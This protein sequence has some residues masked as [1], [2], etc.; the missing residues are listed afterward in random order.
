MEP[1]RRWHL[2]VLFGLGVAA[3]ITLTLVGGFASGLVTGGAAPLGLT[4]GSEITAAALW[5]MSAPAIAAGGLVLGAGMTGGWALR[6]QRTLQRQLERIEEQLQQA[7]AQVRSLERDCEVLAADGQRLD[8]SLSD[9]IAQRERT[10]QEAL[11]RQGALEAQLAQMQRLLAESNT[12][13]SDDLRAIEADVANTW[14]ENDRLRRRLADLE[15]RNGDLELELA[16][17]LENLEEVW[18]HA[19]E[20]QGETGTDPDGG[21]QY[22]SVTEA[23]AAAD[24]EFGDILTIWDSAKEAAARSQF[25]RPGDVYLALAAIAQIGRD[26]FAA[27]DRGEAM[28]AWRDAFRQYGIDF[29][30]T[31]HQVTRS[32]YGSDRD[33]RHQGR[34]QRMLKH[35]TLGR[36]NTVHTLQIY[37]DVDRDNRRIDIGYCGKHLR[38]YSWA[39]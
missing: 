37:F 11:E 2:P 28:G 20:P 15:Q 4:Q 5:P 29:K 18:R 30:P 7:R 13:H 1:R 23:I 16:S 24:Q 33:F 31:E 27:S 14:D 6:R 36:N 35:I 22:G 32:M 38:C 10:R 8:S 12:S 26:Y 19:P 39:S 3:C 34:K 9:A 17:A 25:G 21:D